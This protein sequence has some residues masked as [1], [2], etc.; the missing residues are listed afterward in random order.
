MQKGASS[1]RLRGQGLEKKNE[2]QT[3]RQE[4]ARGWGG[5]SAIVRI[6]RVIHYIANCVSFS[7][8][9]HTG[10]VRQVGWRLSRGLGG[11]GVGG[12][13]DKGGAA[14]LLQCDNRFRGQPGPVHIPAAGHSTLHF[15]RHWQGSAALGD[16][17][18]IGYH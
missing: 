3:N 4:R 2:R 16:V 17:S 15:L 8:H 18:F 7:G 5:L 14:L 6:H 11:F 13:E 10:L 9:F 12:A 1:E